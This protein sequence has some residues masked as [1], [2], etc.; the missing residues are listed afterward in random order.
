MYQQ[1]ELGEQ[2]HN[3]PDLSLSSEWS[4]GYHLEIN[5]TPW[6]ISLSFRVSPCETVST[7]SPFSHMIYVELMD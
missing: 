1:R 6:Y 7:N 5:T 3:G 2:F 4:R